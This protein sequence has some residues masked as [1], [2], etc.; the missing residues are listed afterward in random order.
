M[1]FSGKFVQVFHSDDP[2]KYGFA[3]YHFDHPPQCSRSGYCCSELCERMKQMLSVLILNSHTRSFY[4][5]L[6]IRLG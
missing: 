1:N 6:V 5:H 2:A 3:A 4:F